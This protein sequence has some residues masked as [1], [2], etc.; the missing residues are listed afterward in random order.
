MKF[1]GIKEEI[2]FTVLS[3]NHPLI[4][5]NGSIKA[6]FKPSGRVL[7]VALTLCLYLSNLYFVSIGHAA[8]QH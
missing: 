5:K 6:K 3:Q 8:G 7:S 1:T 2:I 4:H